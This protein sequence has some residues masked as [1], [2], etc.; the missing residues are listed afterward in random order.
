LLIKNAIIQLANSLIF[1]RFFAQKNLFQSLG[2]LLGFHLDPQFRFTVKD[3]PM[4]AE[5]FEK[6]LEKLET[7]VKRLEGGDLDLEASLKQFEE[8]VRLARTCEK[9]LT[10]A[11]KKVEVL[12]KQNGDLWTEPLEKFQSQTQGKGNSTPKASSK[13]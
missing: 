4:P 5:K 2:I 12:L 11:E 1:V 3:E 10:E 8:G 6:S 7:I 9:R 13:E